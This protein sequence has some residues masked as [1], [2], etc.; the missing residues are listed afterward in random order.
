MTLTELRKHVAAACD[1]AASLG[2]DMDDILVTIRASTGEPCV[3]ELIHTIEGEWCH[4]EIKN[5]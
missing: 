1:K 3:I 2:W 4:L 5:K